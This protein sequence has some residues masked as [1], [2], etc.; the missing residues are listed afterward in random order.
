[1]STNLQ[2]TRGKH[3]TLLHFR[4]RHR[5]IP[6]A[7]TTERSLLK[8]FIVQ[9]LAA[10]LGA[11]STVLADWLYRNA[12]I[13][14]GLHAFWVSASIAVICLPVLAWT[15]SVFLGFDMLGRLATGIVVGTIFFWVY[16]NLRKLPAPWNLTHGL[17]PS[18]SSSGPVPPAPK[19]HS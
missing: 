2:R 18:R 5:L 19:L 7:L 16:Q 14:H 10:A 12:R 3:E 11:A 15:S 13:R 9:F 1:V 17:P 4:P 6:A 8:I